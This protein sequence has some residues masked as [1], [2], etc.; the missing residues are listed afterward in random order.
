M[1]ENSYLY[2]DKR[3]RL[4]EEYPYELVE[5]ASLEDELWPAT[6]PNQY[7]VPSK[8][9]EDVDFKR[10]KRDKEKKQIWTP[11]SFIHSLIRN[12]SNGINRNVKV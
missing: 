3:G 8:G 7:F 2:M 5:I 9:R 4:I 6:K 12:I 1:M 10:V 11:F